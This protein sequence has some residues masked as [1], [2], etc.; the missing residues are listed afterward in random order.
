FRREP[1]N[2]L[3]PVTCANLVVAPT[4]TPIRRTVLATPAFLIVSLSSIVVLFGTT[5]LVRC[6][7]LERRERDTRRGRLKAA[8]ERGTNLAPNGV[9]GCV[10]D[11]DREV[12]SQL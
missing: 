2:S 9:L 11:Q 4:I 7:A 5:S 10:A 3:R 12:A 6:L 8:T 1:V